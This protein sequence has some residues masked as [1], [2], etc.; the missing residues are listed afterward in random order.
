MSAM[1]YVCERS[2]RD[3]ARESLAG[4]GGNFKQLHSTGTPAGSL[5]TV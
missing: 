3:M 4:G 5:D 2:E 1:E